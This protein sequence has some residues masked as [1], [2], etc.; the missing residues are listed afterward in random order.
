MDVR[1]GEINATIVDSESGSIDAAALER[2]ARR[3]VA[4]IEQRDRTERN[5]TI[6]RRIASPDPHDVEQYG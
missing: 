4:L 3:V 5:A 6:D 1:I 2:I